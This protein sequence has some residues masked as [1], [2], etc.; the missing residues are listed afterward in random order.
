MRDSPKA[1]IPIM[2]I[3]SASFL[4]SDLFIRRSDSGSAS[5]SGYSKCCCLPSLHITS[6]S[7]CFTEKVRSEELIIS[8]QVSLLLLVSFSGFL[9]SAL[10]GWTI[11]GD[12]EGS[13]FSFLRF[14]DVSPAE[15]SNLMLQGILV[16]WAPG[17]L[18]YTLI[19]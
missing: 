5:S 11:P 8:L 17:F 12:D 13:C 6:S 4:D 10:Y 9:T 3:F 1:I 18:Y 2:T 19:V 14:I 15:M 16:R 7:R